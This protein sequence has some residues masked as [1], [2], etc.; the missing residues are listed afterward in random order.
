MSGQS[1]QCQPLPIKLRK[2]QQGRAPGKEHLG[3]EY[4]EKV[5]KNNQL[6]LRQHY[7]FT[8]KGQFFKTLLPNST[9]TLLNI[10]GLG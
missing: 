2:L 6:L 9:I 8:G 1:L 10:Q 7:P 3:S 5:N 4:Q